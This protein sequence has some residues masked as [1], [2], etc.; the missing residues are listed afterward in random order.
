MRLALLVTAALPLLATQVSAQHEHSP[1]SYAHLDPERT[2]LLPEE[3]EQL[4]SGEGMA[5]ALPAELN[6][7]P[8]PLHVL[9]L[10]AELGLT[11]EQ[12]RRISEIRGAMLEDAV[13]KGEEIITVAGHLADAFRSGDPTAGAISRITAHLGALRGELQAIHLAAHLATR[14]ELTERQVREYDRLRGYSTGK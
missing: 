9:E 6:H 7:F 2:A 10:Q 3:I 8:G 5:L 13:A 4:R 14:G 11:E 12:R 1:S